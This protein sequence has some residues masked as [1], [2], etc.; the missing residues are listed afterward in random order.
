MAA[1]ISKKLVE[2]FFRV[3]EA[4]MEAVLFSETLACVHR[5]KWHNMQED[6]NI[7]TVKYV[8]CNRYKDQIDCNNI[9]LH[10]FH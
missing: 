5:F 10:V 4:K 7:H 6:I 8:F 1:I 2:S 3:V 9:S